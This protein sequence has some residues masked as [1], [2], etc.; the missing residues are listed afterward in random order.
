VT[1]V[2]YVPSDE[3]LCEAPPTP[4]PVPVAPQQPVYPVR[5]YAA[6]N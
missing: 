6:P 4:T 3:V 1:H 5:S 2:S